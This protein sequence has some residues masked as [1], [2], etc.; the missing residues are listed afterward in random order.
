M[1][2]LLY[3][4][5]FTGA[6]HFGDTGIDLENVQETINSDTIFSALINAI[7]IYYGVKEAGDWIERFINDPPFLLSSLFVYYK[8]SYF[9]PKPLDDSSIPDEIKAERG[10]DLKSL[11]WLE[12]EDFLKWKKQNI[13]TI[14]ALDIIKK[15]Q[16]E[17]KRAFVKEI[18]PRVTLDRITQQSSI[19][20]C[21]YIYFREDTGLYGLVAF[22]DS[23]LIEKFKKLLLLLGQTGLGGEKT[24]GCGRF[25]VTF[26]D[27]LDDA[28]RSILQEDSD[29]YVL[30]SLYHP[31]ESEREN[32]GSSLLSYDIV[33]KKG[34]ITSGRYALPLKRKSVGFI[35]EGSVVKAPVKGCL[36]DVTPEYAPSDTLSHS[37]YRYGYAFTVP[38]KE[39]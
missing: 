20:H 37:V 24:Y 16:F 17:Y 39:A 8:D 14:E 25:E 22:R 38:L 33:R 36:I 9:L 34:W 4:L 6:T 13:L 26:D 30:L 3:K 15:K 28:F 23:S 35:T 7:T 18:R 32:L 29:R 10:K 12:R 2:V 27:E 1:D 11:K 21:G 5:R 31:A 19:Y